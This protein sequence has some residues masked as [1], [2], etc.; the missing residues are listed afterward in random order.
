MLNDTAYQAENQSPERSNPIENAANTST[1]RRYGSLSEYA[2]QQG[3]PESAFIDAGWKP[4]IV[5]HS[6]PNT[7]KRRPAIEFKTDTGLRWRFSDGDKPKY[8]SPKGYK[9]CWY[10]SS[11]AIAIARQ[12]GQPLVILNGEAGT[13]VAQYYGIAGTCITGGENNSIPD[14]LMTG[15]QAAYSGPIIIAYDCDEA[16]KKGA[17][18]R[19]AQLRAAGYS[20]R[21]VDLQLGKK[22]DL[23]D[24]CKL[25]GSNALTM[26]L[27][28]PEL[29]FEA[30]SVKPIIQRRETSAPP[31]DGGVDWE[32]ERLLHWRNGVI[33]AVERVTTRQ[34]GKYFRCINPDHSDEHPSARISFDK[35]EDG[36]YVCTCGSHK[37]KDVTSW[38]GPDF[39]EWWK[40]ERA[41]LYPDTT[42]IPQK[43][44]I[45]RRHEKEA[46]QPAPV[47]TSRPFADVS[48]AGRYVSELPI[49]DGDV[50]LISDTGTGKTTWAK[51][52]GIDTNPT[53]R[54]ALSTALAETLDME[55]YQNLTPG[56]LIQVNRLTI[57]LNSIS[58]AAGRTIHTLFADEI[59]QALAHLFGDTFT[60][61]ESETTF[62]TLTAWLQRADRVI[63]ADAYAD[64]IIVRFLKK[65]RPGLKVVVNTRPRNRAA[66]TLWRHKSGLIG[67]LWQLADEN[68]GCVV[69]PTGSAALAKDLEA[70]AI[71]R[72]GAEN[73]MALYQ[74]V[75]SEPERRA[76][77]K[78]INAQIGRYRIF[79]YSPTVG[80]GIDVQTPVRATVG[81]FMAEPLTAPDC[82]QMVNRFRQT[83][84]THVYVQRKEGNR[85]TNPDVIYENAMQNA[86]ATGLVAHFDTHGLSVMT[87][88]QREMLRLFSEIE[89]ADNASKNR[90]FEHFTELAKGYSSVVTCD[91]K[92][93]AALTLTREQRE[94]R[95]KEE[96]S[97]TIAAAA[98]SPDE[99]RALVESGQN[100]PEHAYGLQR[101][102]IEKA[103]GQDITEPNYD[104]LRTHQG[105]AALYLLTDHLHARLEALAQSDRDESTSPVGKRHHYSRRKI[106]L[107]DLVKRVFGRDGLQSGVELTAQHI[108]EAVGDFLAVSG[109]EFRKLFNRRSDLSTDPRR[110]LAW[111]LHRLGLKLERIR[112]ERDGS[113]Q[114]HSVYRVKQESLATMLELAASCYAR[115]CQDAEARLSEVS[116]NVYQGDT[117]I[118]DLGQKRRWPLSRPHDNP[119]Q[120][121]SAPP[122]VPIPP[123][124]AFAELV[125]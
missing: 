55:N 94:A 121:E 16:G 96:K 124:P 61:P 7:G 83:G 4:Q 119:P 45:Q 11:E 18:K 48:G 98:V 9:R 36:I 57:C 89:A 47:A 80:S 105:R 52:Q 42:K 95:L 112:R 81:F 19:V 77:L 111:V 118:H 21:A 10:R 2:T 100:T 54:V 102:L 82:H 23:A 40:A 116:Q 25:H 8:T 101:W 120:V 50:L 58:K 15:L 106:L 12:T 69:V 87:D 88:K 125:F 86:I 26:L 115:Q 84:E 34:R 92:D 113:G 30:E 41:P 13:V 79:I 27:A 33:P 64:E 35:S 63:A 28:A 60:G 66:L 53:H 108:Q 39:W 93:D 37:R 117:R 24:F 123:D 70:Q 43:K 38:V 72:Y 78:H 107:D 14:E 90:L 22:G 5:Q 17:N 29:P 99:F 73:V 56:Q 97:R 49:P 104:L 109:E 74:E 71:E 46:R 1:L 76:F 122:F 44:S 110:F 67:K 31:T 62:N 85:E 75:S 59:R 3:A 103:S 68:A 32:S 65:Y 114:R 6:D 51:G 20:V 91:V